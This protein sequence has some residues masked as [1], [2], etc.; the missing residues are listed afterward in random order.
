M[1]LEHRLSALLQLHLHSLLNTCFQWIEQRQRQDETRII[2]VLGFGESYIRD[3][4]VRLSCTNPSIWRSAT[5]RRNFTSSWPSSDP[6]RLYLKIGHKM[7]PW[8]PLL[9]LQSWCFI[10]KSSLCNSFEDQAPIDY[11]YGCPLRCTD[12]NIWTEYQNINPVNGCQAA[13]PITME[14]V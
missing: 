1:Q 8:W 11:I 2:K 9:R 14:P 10:L 4:T 3:F 6:Q 12:L 5:H 13:R 7:L